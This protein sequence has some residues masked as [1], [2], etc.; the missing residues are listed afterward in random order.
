GSLQNRS[1]K[2]H[3]QRISVHFNT[4]HRQLSGDWSKHSIAHIHCSKADEHSL[5]TQ[6]WSRL[7]RQQITGRNRLERWWLAGLNLLA[8]VNDELPQVRVLYT[9]ARIPR[10][11]KTRELRIDQFGQLDSKCWTG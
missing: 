9:R 1:V 5:S 11:L 2:E 7:S 6:L 3:G 8:V 4:R 10:R